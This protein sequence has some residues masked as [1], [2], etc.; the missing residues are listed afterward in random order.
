M[1]WYF[2]IVTGTCMFSSCTNFTI[3]KEHLLWNVFWK[4][5]SLISAW[6]SSFYSH[7][8]LNKKKLNNNNTKTKN[9][10]TS[11][12]TNHFNITNLPFV[13]KHKDVIIFPCFFFYYNNKVERVNDL[14]FEWLLFSEPDFYLFVKKYI[15]MT[16]SHIY[17][18]NCFV[19]K[20]A[21]CF[22]EC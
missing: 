19:N 9:F 6:N 3:S 12:F 16:I 20:I 7:Y 5:C 18:R 10:F 4:N 13:W 2:F 14:S 21:W 22:I 15:C 8:V 1:R 11:S 17:T